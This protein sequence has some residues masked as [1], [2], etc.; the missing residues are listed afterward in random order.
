MLLDNSKRAVNNILYYIKILAT[1]L[2]LLFSRFF[3][4]YKIINLRIHILKFNLFYDKTYNNY[5]YYLNK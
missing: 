5:Y 1:A 3:D 2:I 4:K